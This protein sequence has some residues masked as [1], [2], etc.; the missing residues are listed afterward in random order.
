MKFK[1]RSCN[2]FLTKI[3]VDLGKSP[4]ANSYALK[5]S[6][7]QSWYSLKTMICNSCWLVQT[8]HNLSGEEIF[9]D[10]YPY[11]SSISKSLLNHSKKYCDKIYNLFLKKNKK[12]N[13]ILELASNDGYL[14]QFFN[15]KKNISRIIGIEPTK[16]A[17]DLAKKK[18]IYTIQ[19]FFDHELSKKI[20]KKYK[21]FDLIIAN[22]VVAHIPEINS[23]IKGIKILLS[24]NGIVTIEF[25]YLIDLI[26]KKLFD[27]IYHEHFFYYSLYSFSKILSRHGLKV[28][29]VEHLKTQG[30]SLRLY[31]SHKNNSK[32]KTSIRLIKLRNSEKNLHINSLIFYKNFSKL[33]FEK[34]NNFLS[35]LLRLKKKNKNI[36]G[37]GAAAKGNTMINLCG[38]KND[39]INFVVDK[40]KFKQKKFLPGSCIPIVAEKFIKRTKPN[41]IIIFPWNISKEISKELNYVRSWKCKFI[42]YQPSLKIF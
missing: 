39:L 17:A 30:G 4:I 3:F 5:E 29:D 9:S 40:N 25:Q 2:K 28:F 23:F 35:L 33:V 34:K 7:K 41:F 13:Q 20:K 11:F 22:N 27:N 6:D 42:T 19:D 1:C 36:I 26:N 12:N 18:K 15:S 16:V 31:I 32:F 8:V 10:Q 37:Y 21:K 38:I 24:Q 14:L